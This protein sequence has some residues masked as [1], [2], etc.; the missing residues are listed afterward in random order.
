MNP[1]LLQYYSRELQHVREM[2]GE[3]AKAFPK[4]AGRLG[5]EGFDCADPYVERLLEGFG[6]LAARVQMKIDAEFPRF[7]QHL[8]ELV[9]P[10]YLAPTPAMTVVQLQPD[11]THPALADGVAVPRGTALH[12]RLDGERATRCEFRTAHALTLSPVELSEARLFTHS[13]ALHG[14]EAALPRG[15]KGG[16]RL[17]LRAIGE[18]KISDFA[19]DHLPIYLRGNDGIA[20]KLYEL[21]IGSTL[22]I[23]TRDAVLPPSSLRPLGFSD[24][25]ALLPVSEQSFPGYRLLQE[26]FACPQRFMFLGIDGLRS[27]F[28]RCDDNEIELTVL[29]SKADAALE[30]LVDQANFALHCTPAINLFARRADRV[31]V[32]GEQ[33]EH[34][35]VVDRTRPRDFEVYRVQGVTGYRSGGGKEIVFQPFYR[36]RDL[37]VEH[38][39]AAFYQVRREK[40]LPSARED[41]RGARSSYAGSETWIALVDTR[42]APYADDLH[43]LGIGVLCTNRDLTI[44]MPLGRGET[45]FTLELEAPVSSVRCVTAPSRPLPSYAQGAVAWR[46]LSHLSLNYASLVDD[47]DGS[48]ARAMRDL[49]A[50]YAPDGDSA[51]ARQIDGLRSIRSRAVTRRLPS[52][53]PIVFGRGLALDVLL[54][55]TGF[56]GASAFLFGAVLAR[57]FEQYVSLNS[58]TETIVSSTTR[59]EIM[60]WAPGSGQCRTL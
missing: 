21:L 33:F 45:D 23:A 10:H 48:G 12:G 22:G 57:F 3:F 9:Y 51:A 52:R 55:E 53:G 24:D 38:A 20:A 7:T 25:E 14:V 46:L 17:K 39:D 5:L 40:R 32:T 56:E 6:F 34:H 29:L 16:L 41:E 1:D 50:L 37:G 43:Q 35:V 4:I 60:R 44:T 8:A 36:M 18:R 26:Y 31:A 58:F 54:D 28:A 42:E 27:H 15:V 49:L 47:H 13:G 30:R 59:G 19:I 11:M 2:G